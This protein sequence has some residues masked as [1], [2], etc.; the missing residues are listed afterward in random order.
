MLWFSCTAG[1][2]AAASGGLVVG[3][4]RPVDGG[5][6]CGLAVASWLRSVVAIWSLVSS[7]NE[8][9]SSNQL[10]AVSCASAT[11]CVA[12]GYPQHAAR[13]DAPFTT[14]QVDGWVPTASGLVDTAGG[15]RSG[16]LVLKAR[17]LRLER[18]P[19]PKL[20]WAKRRGRGCLGLRCS[21]LSLIHI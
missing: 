18:C 11:S 8:G 10:N 15:R 5:M 1:D 4:E 6:V 3:A 21:R 17:V 9:T 13:P 14:A 20:S 19:P 16:Y 7:P 2:G 12:V